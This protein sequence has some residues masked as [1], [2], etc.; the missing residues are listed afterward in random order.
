[1]AIADDDDNEDDGDED[2]EEQDDDEDEDDDKTERAS[3]SAAGLT[4]ATDEV[5]EFPLTSFIVV[6]YC[7]AF[8]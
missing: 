3:G 6:S 8:S 2:E 5:D 7:V 1:M 4:S